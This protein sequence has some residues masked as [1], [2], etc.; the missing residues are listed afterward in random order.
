[1]IVCKVRVP[2]FLSV[3]MVSTVFS[4][5]ARGS[6]GAPLIRASQSAN[7]KFLV[8]MELELSNSHE[9]IRSNQP[10]SIDA[11]AGAPLIKTS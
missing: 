2:L 8:V 6:A 3:L 10:R 1:M 7:G 5:P 11:G 4:L 9:T